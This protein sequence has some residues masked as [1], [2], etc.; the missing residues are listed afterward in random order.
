MGIE[1]N[2]RSESLMAS[3]VRAVLEVLSLV[4][5]FNDRST[6]IVLHR[7]VACAQK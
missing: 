2:N 6:D 1:Y 4:N 3:S 7:R 5:R